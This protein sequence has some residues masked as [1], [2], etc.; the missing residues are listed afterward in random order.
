VKQN[1]P[2]LDLPLAQEGVN[3]VFA[4]FVTSGL[5]LGMQLHPR[6]ATDC[7]TTQPSTVP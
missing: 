7:A 4:S 2:F 1:F 6:A 3:T 5:E